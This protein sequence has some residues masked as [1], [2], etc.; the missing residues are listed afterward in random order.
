MGTY[1]ILRPDEDRCS[2]L[3]DDRRV[4]RRERSDGRVGATVRGRLVF[5]AFV[6]H[7]NRQLP[8]VVTYYIVVV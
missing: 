3:P 4:V 6:A 2:H 8:L 7:N 5:A 1:T